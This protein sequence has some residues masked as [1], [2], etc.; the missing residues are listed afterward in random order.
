V[1]A[2]RATA[3]PTTVYT[4]TGST[5]DAVELDDTGARQ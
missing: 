2:W 1:I 4:V 5:S 3:G